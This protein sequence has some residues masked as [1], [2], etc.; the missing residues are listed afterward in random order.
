MIFDLNGIAKTS[1]TESDVCVI[2][3]GASGITT[4]LELAKEGKRVALC[5]AGGLEYSGRS[6]DCYRGET[7]GDPYFELEISRLRYFGGTTNHWGGWC[8]TFET[9]DFDRSYISE[10]HK[11]PINKGHLDQFLTAACEILGIDPVFNDGQADP[12]G[13]KPINFKMSTVRF[14]DKYLETVKLSEFI[15]LFT[16]ANIVDVVVK[17]RNVSAAIF[18]SY[19]GEILTVRAKTYE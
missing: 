19:T 7:K 9:I 2:G 5:E 10:Q 11:W 8:R 1:V 16:N 12:E 13:I 14:A 15:E 18:R 3:S 4:A 6:Q 17:D